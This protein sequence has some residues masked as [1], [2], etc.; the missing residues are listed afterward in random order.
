MEKLTLTTLSSLLI[1]SG[2]SLLHQGFDRS[3]ASFSVV[4]GIVLIVITSLLVLYERFS[5]DFHRNKGK[6]VKIYLK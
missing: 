4:S 6:K 5:A 3:V 2:I 1:T